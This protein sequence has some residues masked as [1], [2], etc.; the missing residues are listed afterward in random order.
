[1]LTVKFPDPCEVAL[2]YV[3]DLRIYHLGKSDVVRVVIALAAVLPINRFQRRNQTLL[4]FYHHRLP[5]PLC[6]ENNVFA[7]VL[8][9]TL[10]L[11]DIV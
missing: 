8:R 9:L 11:G 3:T 4:C 2:Q 10:E 5:I 6:S 7:D 1:M